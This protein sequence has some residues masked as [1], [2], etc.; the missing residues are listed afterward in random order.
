MLGRGLDAVPAL[1]LASTPCIMASGVE[2]LEFT[3]RSR[4]GTA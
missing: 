2:R 3:F 1:T 4:D